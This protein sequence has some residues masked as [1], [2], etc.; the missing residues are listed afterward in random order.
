M[1]RSPRAAVDATE[2]R[3][4]DYPSPGSRSFSRPRSRRVAGRPARGASDATRRIGR[5]PTRRTPQEATPVDDGRGPGA[6]RPATKRAS[7]E[8]PSYNDSDHVTVVTP[9]IALGIENASGASLHASYL[10]D[11]VSAAS[12]DIVSTASSRWKEV[13]HA[14]TLSAEYKPHDFG[15]TVGTSISSEPDYLS[16]G[17]LCDVTKDFDQK[18]WTRSSGTASATTSSGGAATTGLHAVQRLLA[19]PPSRF[20]QRRR[21]LRPRPRRRSPRSPATSSSRTATSRSLTATSRCSLAASRPAVA[22]GRID[23]HGQQARLPEQPARAAARSR[24][25]LALTGRTRGASTR[26]TLRLEERVYDD[27]WGLVASSTDARWI[28]TSGGVSRSGRTRASTCRIRELL[29]ARLLSGPRQGGTCPYRTGDREL[30][31]LWTIRRVRH[32]VVPG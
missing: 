21:R 28:S 17:A 25:R 10:V 8:S 2:A 18:N 27:T 5:R 9:S 31:P 22:E 19:Q 13:R 15:V 11:V 7:M 29:A 30:G 3:R 12:V 4:P 20:V 16:Y 14:G 26:S 32:Q 23:R 24:R 1:D 6:R